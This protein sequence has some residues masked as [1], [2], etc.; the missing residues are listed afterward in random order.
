[1]KLFFTYIQILMLPIL[2]MG[3][4]CTELRGQGRPTSTFPFSQGGA[5]SPSQTAPPDTTNTAQDSAIANSPQ[6]KIVDSLKASAD[7]KEAVQYEATDSIVYDVKNGMLKMFS[8]GNIKYT[9][10]ELNAERIDVRIDDQTMHAE[11]KTDREGELFGTPEFTQAGETY[12]AREIDYNFNTQKGR[13]KGGRLVQEEA[14][15]LAEVAKY[16]DDGSFHGADGRYTACDADHPHYYIKSKKIKVL[17]DDQVISGPL[18]LV[19]ADFPI[20]VV[21][22]F[23][24]LPNIGK[25]QKNGLIM[26]QYGNADDR[27][28]FLRNIGYYLG[29]NDYLG[30][31]FD[32]DIYTRGGWRLGTTLDYKVRYK[33]NGNFNFE[34]GVLRYNE[35][36]DSDFTR[37]PY[38]RVRWTHNQPI[39]P[40][41]SI[42]ASVNISSSST[43]Q[44]EI[45]FS[46]NDL[47]TNDLRSS[48][49]FRKNFNN[50]P[51]NLTMAADH[52]QDL[53]EGVMSVNLPTFSL[54]VSR[55]MPFKNLDNKYLSPLK[56]LYFT[57]RLNG[58]NSISNVPDSLIGPALFQ[59]Q[60]TL[61]YF[62]NEE[63]TF[64]TVRPLT[65]FINNGLQHS[66]NGGT[67]LKLFNYI[68][69]PI[70]FNYDE[71]WY[72]E[73]IE[74]T[75]DQETNSVI[76]STVPG[77]ARAYSYQANISASGTFYGIYQLTQTKRQIAF[78]QQFNTSVGYSYRP[79][80]SEDRFGFYRKVQ[81]DSL[82]TNFQTYSIFQNGIYL[83][84]SAGESQSIN[85]SLSSI[86]AMKYRKKESFDP[87]FDEKE[88]KFVRTDILKSL[89]LSSSYNLAADSFQLS[90]FRLAA[91]T[92]FLKNKINFNASATFDPY[93]FGT[94]N[95]AF[96][97]E[98]NSA[99]RQNKFLLVEEGRL[100]RLTNV[101]FSL[102]TSLRSK[103]KNERGQKTAGFDEQEYTEV[104][105]NY[106]QYYDFDIPWNVRLGYNFNYSK[107]SLNPAN[108]TSTVRV[109]GDMNFTDNWKLVLTTGYDLANQKAT[110]TSITIT[111]PLHCWQFSFNWVPFGA[112]K[113]YSVVISARS[114]TLSALRLTKN[115]FWQDRFRTL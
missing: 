61:R 102:N 93:V 69:V 92:G 34:Y 38:W 45:S 53:N 10:I 28:F 65:D 107:T 64:L 29:I 109:S 39:D 30:V 80:F 21:I 112:R 68:N 74:R 87:E 70:T 7:L 86:I 98:G 9:D 14:F 3:L 25:G 33:Y 104:M 60:D 106:D 49:S 22:P 42:N 2:V 77:F 17:N 89:S 83:R 48:I 20:P 110:T 41:A 82:G 105:R 67:N 4:L 16:Q 97:L 37:N 12:K 75:Y 100:A 44:R 43:F 88:D 26:P 23:A 66:I 50:L 57:Y 58:R 101:T 84:P 59:T 13:I 8:K 56:Q 76:T 40:T 71:S 114:S 1:M 51:I 113:S 11:G 31:T 36:T 95:V 85:F 96:P 54:N 78:R 55:Q 91:R 5:P 103:Q 19:V 108:I 27:G 81:T 24:F 15:I 35:P 99:R 63:D 32:G 72:T 73:T 111:R 62:A 90:T 47:F 79:D 18:N 94:D 46:T 6:Q 52:S 115:E